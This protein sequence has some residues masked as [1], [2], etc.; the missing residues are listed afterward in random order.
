MQLTEL[1]SDPCWFPAALDSKAETMTFARVDRNSL[2]AEPFLDQ[3]MSGSVTGYET[4]GLAAVIGA[5]AQQRQ[6]TPTFLFHSAFCCSTLLARSLDQHGTTLALKEPDILMGLANAIRVD[7][8]LRKSAQRSDALVRTVFTLLSRNFSSAENV[9]VKPTNSAN[10]L[11]PFAIA[12]GAPVLLLYGGLRSFLVSVLKKGEACKS[13]VRQQYNI[14]A[15]D[16][17]GV[18]AIPQRQAVGFTDLQIAATVWRHQME[19]FQRAIDSSARK[20]LT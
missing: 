16:S 19:L 15:L 20:Q 17:V 13:F 7:A 18:A 9:L 6:S 11:L 14:F 10:N 1:I 3:R 4:A 2:S 5:V 12:A 8:E